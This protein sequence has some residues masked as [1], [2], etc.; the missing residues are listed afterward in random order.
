MNCCDR[1]YPLIALLWDNTNEY[2]FYMYIL[3]GQH[4]LMYALYIIQLFNIMCYVFPLISAICYAFSLIMW[5]ITMY[6]TF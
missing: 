1:I 5:K 4:C 6:Y 3:K 2:N